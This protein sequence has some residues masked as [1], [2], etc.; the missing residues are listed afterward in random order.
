MLTAAKNL[1]DAGELL[2]AERL[3]AKTLAHTAM[4]IKC[5]DPHKKSIGR[6]ASGDSPGANPGPA[7]TDAKVTTRQNYTNFEKLTAGAIEYINHAD[8]IVPLPNNRPGPQIQSFV[9]YQGN[10]AGASLGLPR[11]YALLQANSSYSAARAET[12]IAEKTFG[13]D[14]KWLERYVL[15]FELYH[16]INYGVSTGQIAAPTDPMWRYKAS[17][18]HPE[19]APIDRLKSS[20]A[21]SQ[22]LKNGTANL[23]DLNGPDWKKH[24]DQDVEIEKY[25]REEMA[26][27][28]PVAD[29]GPVDVSALKQEIIGLLKDDLIEE[30]KDQ[31]EQEQIPDA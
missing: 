4:A 24:V 21:D 14:Q 31:L 19:V 23:A 8:E 30:L 10:T 12:N 28:P 5:A 16:V 15:D 25:R 6:A 3:S 11:L 2:D 29:S 22:D 20:K 26:K 1:I 9:D 18:E 7:L 17:W 13:K 27:L